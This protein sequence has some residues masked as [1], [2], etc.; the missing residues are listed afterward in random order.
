[1]TVGICPNNEN[2]AHKGVIGA[3]RRLRETNYQEM[4]TLVES[5]KLPRGERHG[6]RF[7]GVTPLFVGYQVPGLQVQVMATNVYLKAFS[8]FARIG[9]LAPARD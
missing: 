1:M 2:S 6:F 3:S 8:I 7:L 9:G 5:A 4:V